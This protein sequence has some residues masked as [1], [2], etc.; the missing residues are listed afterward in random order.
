MSGLWGSK[1]ICDFTCF[2]SPYM[3]YIESKATWEDRFDFFHDNR[4]SKRES[5]REI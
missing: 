1:N 4:L 3:W 2:V 5:S